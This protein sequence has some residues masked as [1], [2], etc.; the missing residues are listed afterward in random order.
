MRANFLGLQ[1]HGVPDR[2]RWLK[3]IKVPDF[4]L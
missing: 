1:R 4:G 3:V 2:Q